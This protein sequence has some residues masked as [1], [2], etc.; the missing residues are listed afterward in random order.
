MAR[1]I[2]AELES[3][4]YVEPGRKAVIDRQEF[5]HFGLVACKNNRHVR[6]P[7][8]ALNEYIDS[9][10]SVGIIHEVVCFVNEKNAALSIGKKLIHFGLSIALVTPDKITSL[11]IN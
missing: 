1:L 8:H 6:A 11:R 2:V 10:S 9:V 3:G 5:S 7:L 4:F